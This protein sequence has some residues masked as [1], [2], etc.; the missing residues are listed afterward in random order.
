VYD[1]VDRTARR[2][3]DELVDLHQLES[4]A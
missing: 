2:L 1:I 4:A 3:L